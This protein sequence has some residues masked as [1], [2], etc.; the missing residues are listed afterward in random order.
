[1]KLCAVSSSSRKVF[2]VYPSNFFHNIQR[3]VKCVPPRPVVKRGDCVLRVCGERQRLISQAR[4]PEQATVQK[5]FGKIG[6]FS[7]AGD[8]VDFQAVD[9]AAQ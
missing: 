1:M 4:K 8:L 9:E 5:A 3:L 7:G 6:Q 2:G